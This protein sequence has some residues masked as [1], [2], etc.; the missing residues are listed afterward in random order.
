MATSSSSV[1]AGGSVAVP[2]PSEVQVK[3]TPTFTLRTDLTSAATADAPR[4][5]RPAPPMV[6]TDHVRRD[7]IMRRVLLVTDAAALLVAA[8]I[9]MV[10]LSDPALGDLAALIALVP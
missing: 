8:L 1:R 2:S 4:F 9:T 7:W 5:T 3:G 6:H 10:A